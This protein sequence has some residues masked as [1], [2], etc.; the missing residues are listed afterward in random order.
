VAIGARYNDGING[1]DS[2][3]VRVF[4]ASSSARRLSEGT[5]TAD[6]TTIHETHTT[7]AG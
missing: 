4:T 5:T 7:H 6:T 1:A 3:H 2:G